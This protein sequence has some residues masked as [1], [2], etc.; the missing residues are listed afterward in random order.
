MPLF[1]YT[2]LA[3]HSEFELLIRGSAV[4]A[5]PSCGAT[6]LE[7]RLSMFAVSSDGTQA[8]SR[9]RLGARQRERSQRNQAERQF[10][11]SDHHDD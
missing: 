4:P 9:Q 3:C 1:E 5:C 6:S 7:K 2:C 10:Y 8:R 11:K